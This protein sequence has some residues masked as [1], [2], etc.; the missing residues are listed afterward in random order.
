MPVASKP[1]RDT[2]RAAQPPARDS[3]RTTGRLLGRVLASLTGQRRVPESRSGTAQAQRTI[4]L[5]RALLSERGEVSGTRLA[6]RTLASYQALQGDAL[7]AFLDLLVEEFSPDREKVARAIAA[8]HDR[9]SAETLAGLQT[10]VESPCQELFRRLNLAP[11]GTRALIDL[12]RQL[13][14]TLSAN[15]SRAPLDRDLTHLFRS[16]FNRG[17]LVL[18]RVDWQ[19]PAAILEKLIQ[20]ERVH[21]IQDWRDLRRRLQDDRRCYA[22]FHPA[23]PDEPLIFVEVALARGMS[24][25]VDP[26]LAADAPV[27]NGSQANSAIFYSITNCQVGLS[28]ISFGNFLIKQVVEEL[29]RELPRIRTFASLSPMPGFSAWLR[30]E[31]VWTTLSAELRKQLQRLDAPDSTSRAVPA[32]LKPEVMRLGAIYLLFAKRDRAPLDSVA[33]FHLT[34]GARAERLNWMA[35]TS[36]AGLRQSLGLMVNYVYELAAVEQNHEAFARRDE[37]IASR[38]LRRQATVPGRPSAPPP[39]SAR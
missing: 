27:S 22:F 1:L 34:N 15:P 3:A 39:S 19:C 5:C 38:E 16:W 35:D 7:E 36:D 11:T 17:F 31:K 14:P 32:A 8:Y 21:Q 10:A 25:N 30:S 2:A 12:R 6:I 13:L 37:I 24:G 20:Y 28:G 33:R 4:E 26:L 18:R 23:L 9:P 29:G